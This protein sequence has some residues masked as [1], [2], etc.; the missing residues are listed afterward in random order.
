MAA[1][2]S[3]MKATSETKSWPRSSIRRAPLANLKSART[4]APLDAR[5]STSAAQRAR[6]TSR[7]PPDESN[8]RA[9]PP[10]TACRTSA[11][12]SNKKNFYSIKSNGSKLKARRIA[13]AELNNFF[14]CF[15]ALAN[16]YALSRRAQYLALQIGAPRLAGCKASILTSRLKTC[17]WPRRRHAFCARPRCCC[18]DTRHKN[19]TNMRARARVQTKCKRPRRPQAPNGRAPPLPPEARRPLRLAFGAPCFLMAAAAAAERQSSGEPRAAASASG[20]DSC[21]GRDEQPQRP[22]AANARH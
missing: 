1:A 17:R 15:Y 16:L 7:R 4:R 3:P 20:G 11:S 19:A 22:A 13:N 14:V 12:A 6:L 21:R 18:C 9:P 10:Q 8:E 2:A 5:R